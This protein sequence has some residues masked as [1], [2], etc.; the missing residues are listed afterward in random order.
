MKSNEIPKDGEMRWELSK[1]AAKTM[2]LSVVEAIG[3]NDHE[4][5]QVADH[6]LYHKYYGKF[7]LEPIMGLSVN[8]KAGRYLWKH[9]VDEIMQEFTRVMDF[10]LRG[11]CTKKN[12]IKRLAVVHRNFDIPEEFLVY[13]ASM[14]RD[15]IADACDEADL[16]TF[17]AIFITDL[18]RTGLVEGSKQGYLNLC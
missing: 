12:T 8:L 2:F 13:I 3:A 15:S 7:R 5:I 1:H 17:D 4:I 14:M 10:I 16:A 11:G 9:V 18:A 6:F